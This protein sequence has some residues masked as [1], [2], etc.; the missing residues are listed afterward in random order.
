MEMAAGRTARP[1]KEEALSRKLPVPACVRQTN[2]ALLLMKERAKGITWPEIVEELRDYYCSPY[3]R[4]VLDSQGNEEAKQTVKESKR[5]LWKRDRDYLKEAGIRIQGS[6]DADTEM[7]RYSIKE[8]GFSLKEEELNPFRFAQLRLA[9]AGMKELGGEFLSDELRSVRLKWGLEAP[10]RKLAPL[11]LDMPGA[12]SPKLLNGLYEAVAARRPVSFSYKGAK[13]KGYRRRKVQPAA[14]IY[15][16]GGWHL[17]GY[18]L[19]AEGYRLF[20]I[21]SLKQSQGDLKKLPEAEGAKLEDERQKVEELLEVK[22]WDMGP[23]PEKKVEVDF[24]REAAGRAGRQLGDSAAFAPPKGKKVRATI[25]ARNLDNLA[26]W[27][28]R[29]GDDAV[30][31]APEEAKAVMAAKLRRILAKAAEGGGGR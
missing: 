24:S 25:R 8:G 17:V 31:V 15:R 12:E 19:E 21:S 28:L 5:T 9:L 3:E 23:G 1:A 2:L 30:V 14:M 11:F 6:D 16:W 13:D 7:T 18:D 10:D 26:G 27:L 22:P 4:S 29:F 20:R